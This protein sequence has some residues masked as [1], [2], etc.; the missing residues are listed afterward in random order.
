MLG[1]EGGETN[2]D[3]VFLLSALGRLWIE[4]VYECCSSVKKNSVM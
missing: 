3:S 2:W 1:R 4:L